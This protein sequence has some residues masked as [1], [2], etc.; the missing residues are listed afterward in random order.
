MISEHRKRV[1]KIQRK[2]REYLPFLVV[3]EKGKCFWCLRPILIITSVP[4]ERRI[5]QTFYEFEYLDDW[6]RIQTSLIATT[7]HLYPRSLGGKGN[8]RNLV[9]SCVRCNQERNIKRQRRQANGRQK[10][11]G[12]VNLIQRC[13]R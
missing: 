3:R 4:I 13:V 6:G 12:E 8:I 9:A 2:A 1:K 11:A 7:D 10:E 5:R